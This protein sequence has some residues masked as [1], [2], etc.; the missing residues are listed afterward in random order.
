[1][2]MKKHEETIDEPEAVL[3]NCKAGRTVLAVV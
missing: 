1:M 2:S 3:I